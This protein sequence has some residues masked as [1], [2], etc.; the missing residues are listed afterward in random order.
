MKTRSGAPYLGGNAKKIRLFLTN[1]AL[2]FKYAS[3]SEYQ[4][5]DQ[6]ASKS[7]INYQLYIISISKL[8]VSYERILIYTVRTES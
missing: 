5:S 6:V 3:C 1:Y 4:I 8:I 2:N 7:F